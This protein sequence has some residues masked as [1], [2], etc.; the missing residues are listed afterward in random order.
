MRFVLDASVTLTWLL[1]DAG[2]RSETYAFDVLKRVRLPETDIQVPV[3][4]AL[5]VANVVVRSESKGAVTE[6]QSEAFLEMLRAAPI[7]TDA[8]TAAHAVSDTLQLARRHRLSVYD[9]SYLE[10]ALRSGSPL[11]TLDA[12]LQRAASKAGVKLLKVA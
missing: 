5:E 1:R 8:T 4:W 6:A 12:D 3:T 9:A 2:A 10:L 7:T 11:A